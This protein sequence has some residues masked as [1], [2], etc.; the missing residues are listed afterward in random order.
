MAVSMAQA[1]EDGPA[2]VTLLHVVPTGAGEGDLIRAEQVFHYA[3]EGIDYPHVDTL[4]V[5]GS[6]VVNTVLDQARGYDLIVT[7]ATEEPL[8]RNLLIG[9]IAEQIARRASVTVIVIK[10]RSSPLHSFLRQTVLQPSTGR[11]VSQS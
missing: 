7:G 4:I 6:N 5:E 1:G 9:N 3:L 11:Q 8:F 2:S 10:R